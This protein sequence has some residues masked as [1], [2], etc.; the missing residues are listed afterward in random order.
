MTSAPAVPVADR[1]AVRLVRRGRTARTGRAE[2]GLARRTVPGM[3]TAFRAARS[4]VL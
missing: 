4:A 2:S 3:R 1:A